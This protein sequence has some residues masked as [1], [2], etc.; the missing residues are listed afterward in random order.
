MIREAIELLSKGKDLTATQMEEVMEEIMT[1]RLDTPQIIS[2]LTNLNNKGETSEELTAAATVMRRHAIKV[3]TKHKVILDTCGTGGDK[4]GSFNIS[5]AAAFIASGAGIAV[6]KHGNRS[7]SSKSG[8]ADILEA[9]GVNI[10]MAKEKIERCLNEI[11]ITFLFAPNFHPAMKYAM[12]ARKQ[13]AAKT[14]FNFLG[15]LCN[16]A[17]ATHQLIGVYDRG[18]I[19]IIAETLAK[20]GT[21]H[22]LVVHGKDGMDEI[23]L[24]AKTLVLEIYGGEVR[25]RYEI[26][27]EDFGYKVA[28]LDNFRGGTAVDNSK[29]LLELLK[30]KPVPVRDVALL[31]SAA[32]IYVAARAS[33]IKEAISLA[34]ASIESGSAFEKL[35]LLKEYSNR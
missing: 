4:K 9:L 19:D 20:L 3:N 5:T 11:G 31:N 6:A 8:S 28:D 7:V 35:Q 14:I 22:A 34:C 12:P 29:T 30:N 2:L 23:T 25:S 10:N 17:S 15:P 32:A 16:P 33:S 21:E 13:I 1:G 24:N 26:N 18:W 27:P